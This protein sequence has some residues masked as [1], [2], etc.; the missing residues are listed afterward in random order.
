VQYIRALE[1]LRRF[2]IKKEARERLRAVLAINPEL[3]RAQAKLVLLEEG[4][5]E[6]HAELEKLR[7]LSP[8][9]PVVSIAGPEITS[10]YEMSTAVEKARGSAPSPAP[11]PAPSGASPPPASPEAPR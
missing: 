2:A 7:V 4:I 10:E 3:V 1:T 9:H 5:A 6:R 11:A 8:K